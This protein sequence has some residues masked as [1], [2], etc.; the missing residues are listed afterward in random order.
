MSDLFT[1]LAQEAAGVAMAVAPRGRSRFEAPSLP[2]N[3]AS[4]S[5][6]IAAPDGPL[7]RAASPQ[8]GLRGQAQESAA[9]QSLPQAPPIFSREHIHRI[10]VEDEIVSRIELRDETVGAG[11]EAAWEMSEP[12]REA[13][14][15]ARAALELVFEPAK[16][17]FALPIPATTVEPVRS[18]A[19]R[20]DAA[21][22]AMAEPPMQAPA[23]PQ[24]HMPL[25]VEMLAPRVAESVKPDSVARARGEPA[26]AQPLPALRRPAQSPPA[27][28]VT[29]GRVEVR[30]VTPPPAARSAP[31]SP[32]PVK[33]AM[34]LA[35]YLDQR[36]R[37]G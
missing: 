2:L 18:A 6:G 26:R 32:K 15:A 5:E 17:A 19:I 34:S 36:N 16:T 12:M 8:P 11:R 7:P 21:G 23:A 3:L 10:E 20:E 27:V 30:A 24:R 33:P 22:H 25:Q 37:S 1:A 35:D 4:E 14:E 29:I 28:H 13:P 9:A 31:A